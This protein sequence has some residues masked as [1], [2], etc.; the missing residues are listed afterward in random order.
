MACSSVLTAAQ[1]NAADALYLG[2]ADFAIAS[3]MRD[4]TLQ[5]ADQCKLE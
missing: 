4:N 1:V 3:D 2:M 5:S